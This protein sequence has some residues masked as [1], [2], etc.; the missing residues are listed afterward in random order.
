MES[1]NSHW[2]PK[3]EPYEGQEGS[4]PAQA[5]FVGQGRGGV[6]FFVNC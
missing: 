2:I 4:V 3:P 1:L 6:F 5:L